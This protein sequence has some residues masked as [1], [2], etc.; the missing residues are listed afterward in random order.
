MKNIF[1]VDSEN[2]GDAWIKLF[3][4]LNEDDIILVFYSNKSPNMSYENLILLKHSP[5]EPEFILCENGTDNS[6][7][8]QL[9][10]YLG[11]LTVKNPD[12]NLIIVSKDKGF[13]SVVHFWSERGFHVCRKAPSIFH[14]LI[15]EEP[16][17]VSMSEILEPDSN[18]PESSNTERN[19]TTEVSENVTEHTTKEESNQISALTYIDEVQ[20]DVLLSCIGKSNLSALHNMLKAIY[21]DT[22]GKEIYEMVKLPSYEIP[23]VNWQKKTKYRKFLNIIYSKNE[24]HLSDDFFKKLYPQKANLKEINKLFT[25]K[26][27]QEKG[28][29]YYK[30][31][32]TYADFLQKTF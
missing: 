6:L 22:V 28:T 26:Y 23:T 3:D 24:V 10:T 17:T 5:V 1:F 21:G 12:D 16:T 13:D 29:E 25:G 19:D 31:Y 2:V 7:D 4:Y 9:V 11:S 15:S 32:K 18:F 20:L 30:I 27:G 14:T 8:F